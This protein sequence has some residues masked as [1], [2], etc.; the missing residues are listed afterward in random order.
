MVTVKIPLRNSWRE[1]FTNYS[2]KK[3]PIISSQNSP[4]HA[5]RKNRYETTIIWW[6]YMSISCVI[7]KIIMPLIS[8][9]DMQ[10]R[11][12]YASRSER[13]G[14]VYIGCLVIIITRIT[15]REQVQRIKL[16]R[17]I[18]YTFAIFMIMRN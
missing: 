17:K 7:K 8:F 4:L 3:S 14:I 13:I 15:T 6:E 10:E 12:K 16:N 1:N 2:I 11:K 18:L 5:A 9:L